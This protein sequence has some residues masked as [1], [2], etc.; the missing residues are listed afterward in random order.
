MGNSGSYE[1]QYTQQPRQQQ[2]GYQQQQQYGQQHQQQ[3][4]QQQ[5]RY[6]QQQQ[7]GQ[8]QQHG[9]QHQLNQQY[10]DPYRQ[11]VSN[12]MRYNNQNRGQV[13]SQL[14]QRS[15]DHIRYQQNDDY[16]YQI[17]PIEATSLDMFNV[18]ETI[19]NI[20]EMEKRELDNFNKLE[21]ERRQRFESEQET[22]RK[23]LNNMIEDF[24]R[25]YNPYNILGLNEQCSAREAK[26]NY[27]KLALKYHPDKN[28]E[29][30]DYEFK[31]ITQSYYYILNKINNTQKYQNKMSQDVTYQEYEDNVNEPKYNIHLDKD[32]FNLNKFNKVFDQYKISSV[33]DDGYGDLMT[34]G[35]RSERD[36]EL[37]D[38]QSVFGKKFN[39]EI[40]N[41]NFDKMKSNK[42]TEIMEYQEPMALN[43]GSGSCVE[44]GVGKLDNY[45]SNSMGL[46]YTDYK[47]AHYE[48][49]MI[50]VHD[51]KVKQYKNVKDLQNARSRLS[52]NMS[53][54]D[55]E[56]ERI[57]QNQR[58]Q[59]E[60][61]R[62]DRLERHDNMVFNQYNKVNQLLIRQ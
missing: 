20:D 62:R 27:R 5:N 59:N 44:L 16:N 61:N 54:K 3:Y 39:K 49:N 33:Y 4:G 7:Y 18:N 48:N 25:K 10:I 32:N 1:Q 57:R 15:N 42:S 31:L 47:Q 46:G 30:T 41:M 6:Q 29:K 58:E 34:G 9:Q 23:R 43:S 13:N 40:F 56:L 2:N 35:P 19:K 28:G 11:N 26:V 22:R 53:E 24:E 45:G 51:V 17:Q 50:N 60:Q 55:R 36:I 14:I 21:R 12:D 8:Q 38:N 37:N 52:Y